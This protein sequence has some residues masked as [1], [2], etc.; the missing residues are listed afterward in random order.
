M[1]ES[2]TINSARNIVVNV[3]SQFLAMALRFIART[4]FIHYLSVEFLGV[5]GLFSNVLSML[6]LADLGITSALNYSLYKPIR[7]NDQAQIKKLMNY[8]QKVYLIIAGFVLGIGLSLVPF[9]HLIVNLDNAVPYIRVY[10][11]LML[12][13]VVM[14]YLFVYKSSLVI[15]SQKEYLVAQITIFTQ[16]LRTVVQIGVLVLYRNFALYLIVQIVVE[17]IDNLIVSH[18]ANRIYPFLK[19]NH[20]KL[21]KQQRRRI[22]EDIKSIF[23]YRFGSII[24]SNTTDIFISVMIGTIY[25]GYYSN[26]IM[27]VGS[28]STMLDL[29]FKSLSAS[30]GNKNAAQ[31]ESGKQNIFQLAAFA[32]QWLIGFSTVSFFILLTPF[33]RLWLGEKFVLSGL[34]VFAVALQFFIT[35]L[36]SV[37]AIYRD[38]TG[39]FKET[40]Y[41]Y[42]AAAALNL[43]FG[44][45]FGKFWGIAGILLGASLAKL[46]TAFWFE[47]KILFQYYFKSPIWPYFKSVL[48][49]AIVTVVEAAL[50]FGLSQWLSLS[51]ISG[52][53]I[54]MILC[55]VVVNGGNL[56]VYRNDA[57]FK[58]L[59]GYL[60]F[61]WI[62]FINKI[63][64]LKYGKEKE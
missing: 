63:G 34:I 22:L 18:T 56:L 53:I 51:G 64:L 55:V 14:S 30:I 45:V 37:T 29:L 35:G 4:V 40:K 32:Y 5:N 31:S 43:L 12:L 27:I 2:R 25:V 24:M 33:I 44:F 58:Q 8:F 41:A 19:N 11:V 21:A 16:I 59:M 23:V 28:I 61:I 62:A 47:P 42:L 26:Y 13:G 36:M 57:D 54:Q 46:L 3:S 9:L 48:R 1:E 60:E 39:I 17:F 15:A 50:L 49:C 20:E 6:T 52:L 38:T 10:Y 7:E